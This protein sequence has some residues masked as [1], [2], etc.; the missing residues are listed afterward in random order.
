MV[1][2][3]VMEMM[4]DTLWMR[5]GKILS[6]FTSFS[7]VT[8]VEVVVQGR[9]LLGEFFVKIKPFQLTSHLVLA[10]S[11]TTDNF[12]VVIGYRHTVGLYI[13]IQLLQ[14]KPY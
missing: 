1:V 6:C 3:P 13:E 9:W 7:M 4:K 10:F 14:V 8:L 11:A 2:D 5:T 12:T